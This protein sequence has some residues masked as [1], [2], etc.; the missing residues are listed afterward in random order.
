MLSSLKLIHRAMRLAVLTLWIAV[1][2]T[3]PDVPQL[4]GQA[5]AMQR[6]SAQESQSASSPETPQLI[7][8]EPL[9]AGGDLL[10]IQVVGTDFTCGAEKTTGCE[11]RVSRSGEIALPFLGELRVAGLTV[12]QAE[13]LVARKLSDGELIKDPQVT[14]VQKE[15]STQDISVLG[16]V[17]KPGMYPLHGAHSILEAISAAGGTTAKAGSEV[18][19]T[20]H[21]QPN[22]LKRV[23][24]S[25]PRSGN[26]A[27]MPGDTIVVSKAGIVY[28]VGDVRQPSGFVMDN[29]GLTVLQAIA[30]AQGAKSTASLNNARLLRTTS[31]GRREIPIPIG[32]ML[33]NKA[34]DLKLQ[35]DD[36]IFVPNS[37]AKSVTYRGLEAAVQ[38]ATN[39][40]IYR[41]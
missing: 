6:T 23:N 30:M 20:P 5:Q 22:T 11:V 15:T 36:I 1:I 7:D 21:D 39:L 19:I 40:A 26:V 35:A 32:K 4:V 25:D 24:L 29:S 17:Q 31:Q 12:V 3:F 9:I 37:A 10:E 41:P 34:E 18:T 33:A 14:I 28:V 8:R 13:Q 38:T 2:A 16:E 27:V